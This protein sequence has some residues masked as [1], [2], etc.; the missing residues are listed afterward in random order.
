MKDPYLSQHLRE[1]SSALLEL[2]S[3]SPKGVMGVP[4]DKKLRSSMTLFAAVAEDNQ[5]FLDVLDKYFGGK[6]D[7]RTLHMLER[8]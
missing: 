8:Q 4:D 3:N 1:I 6:Q 7:T 2:E 5:V